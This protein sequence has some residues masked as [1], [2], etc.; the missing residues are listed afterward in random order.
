MGVIPG[1]LILAL[2]VTDLI[3]IISY[4]FHF[5]HLKQSGWLVLRWWDSQVRFCVY[6]LAMIWWWTLALPYHVTC[7]ALE[8]V[9]HIGSLNVCSFCHCFK[10][11]LFELLHFKTHKICMK[12]KLPQLCKENKYVC[13]RWYSCA[14][15]PRDK[16][17][18]MLVQK[19]GVRLLRLLLGPWV[20]SNDI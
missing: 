11:F 15:H 2:L 13:L 12:L 19:A 3:W 10:C 9:S 18:D 1:I 16:S 8:L 5:I 17:E 14:F 7:D 6:V 20:F 4:L